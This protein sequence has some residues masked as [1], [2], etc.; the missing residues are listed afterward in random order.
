MGLDATAAIAR[1]NLG[2]TLFRADRL[3][4]ARLVIEK[5]LVMLKA[6]KSARLESAGYAYLAQVR[7]AEDR[8]EDALVAADSALSA[9]TASPERA[10]ARAVRAF[11]LLRLD[12]V[13]DAVREATTAVTMLDE[14]GGI[15]EGELLIRLAFARALGAAD[16]SDE[17]RAAVRFAHDRLAAR[18][19]TIES[20]ALKASC[21]ARIP[22]HAEVARVAEKWVGLAR[23]G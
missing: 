19:A 10:Y 16:R 8:P 15:D 5:A 12:R 13:E 6:Q 17:A 7:L 3:E 11:A 4:E 18:L 21:L 1:L 9:A 22:E 23:P 20:P 14:M 2:R